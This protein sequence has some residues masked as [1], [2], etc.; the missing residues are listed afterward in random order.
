MEV[1]H[2]RLAYAA[3]VYLGWAVKYT[4]AGR[5]IQRYPA[6]LFA[7]MSG[8]VLVS[9]LLMKFRAKFFAAVRKR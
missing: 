6:G 7:V 4:L 5:P 2:I 1:L 3:L 8:V 9:R